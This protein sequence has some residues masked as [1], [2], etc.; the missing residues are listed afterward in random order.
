MVESSLEVDFADEYLNQ[1][2]QLN[3][4]LI[5]RDQETDQVGFFRKYNLQ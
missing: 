1:Y 4:K 2:E 5:N 3:K